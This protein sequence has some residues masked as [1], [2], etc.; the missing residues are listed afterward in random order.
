MKKA[1]LYPVVM[2]LVLAVWTCS[3][4]HEPGPQPSTIVETE[5]DSAL[6]VFGVLRLDGK[7]NSSFFYIER[8]YQYQEL[9]TIAWDESFI[10]IITNA[11]VS[12]RRLSDAKDYPFTY[13]LDSLRGEIYTCD[14]FIPTAEETYALTVSHDDFR[15]VT[16]TT[17]VPA[18]PALDADSVIVWGD[19]VYFQQR[20]AA[21]VY[22]YDII[23]L[24]SE[25]SLQYRF[26]NRD[27]ATIPIAF[28]S[29]APP[30]ESVDIQV[31]GYDANLAEYLTTTITLKPQTYNETVTTVTG[32]YG[33]FG[34]VS[35]A[36]VTVPGAP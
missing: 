16:D 28:Q 9:D 33:V 1:G 4:P 29:T 14:Y 6:N 7:I 30:E 12:V 26:Q 17:T 27:G 5:F 36:A 11:T 13:E 31:Y 34:S 23:M 10:P 20:T 2:L 21:D 3:L 24:S 25:D 32:G 15:T 35:V 18:V 8:T 22:L 19:M